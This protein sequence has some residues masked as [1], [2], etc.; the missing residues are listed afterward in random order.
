MIHLG[1]NTNI[2]IIVDTILRLIWCNHPLPF[3]S[4]PNQFFLLSKSVTSYLSLSEENILI[5]V[6]L[7]LISSFFS[8]SSISLI[9][10]LCLNVC[11]IIRAFFFLR[12]FDKVFLSLILLIT[13][14]FIILSSTIFLNH[15]PLVRHFKYEYILLSASPIFQVSHD[16]RSQHLPM[17]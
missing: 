7:F 16:V 5:E 15:S 11:S 13:S 17:L 9:D 10:Q 8:R 3:D 14:S 1:F 12:F 6:F 2:M 4:I